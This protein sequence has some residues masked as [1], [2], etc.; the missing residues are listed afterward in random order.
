LAGL[1]RVFDVAFAVA[2]DFRSAGFQ[3]A[4]VEF[5]LPLLLKLP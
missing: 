4:G 5:A 1:A 2:F 3:P